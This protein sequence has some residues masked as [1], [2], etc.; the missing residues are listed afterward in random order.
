MTPEHV[1]VEDL[2][3]R[4]EHQEVLLAEGKTAAPLVRILVDGQWYVLKHLSHDLDWLARAVGDVGCNACLAWERGLYAALPPEIDAAVVGARREGA[5]AVLVM[6]DVGDLLVPPGDDPVTHEQ[7]RRFIAHM[8][9]MHAHFAGERATA[10]D[11]TPLPAKLTMLSELTARVEAALG[12]EGGVPAILGTAWPAL[13]AVAPAAGAVATALAADP[14]PLV[15]ALEGS[16]TTLSHGDWKYGN[17]GSHPDGRTIL[18]DWAVPGVAPFCF[19]L[20]YY[21]AINARRFTEPK[22]AVVAAYREE[23]EQ[24]GVSTLGWFERQLELALLGAFVQLGWEK[25]SE[26]NELGWW[27]ERVL[28]TAGTL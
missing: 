9:T 1:D 22:E 17:L 27:V 15:A 25:V 19:D 4:A 7:H 6:R 18:L 28:P 13:R 5:G 3:R 10:Y 26:P 20:A 14:W 16:P 21:L 24:R 23:L 11:L 8:A 2:L 12:H